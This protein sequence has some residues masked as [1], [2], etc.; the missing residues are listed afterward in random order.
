MYL[1]MLHGYKTLTVSFLRYFFFIASFLHI[2][3]P[4][5][6]FS[7]I[8]YG[9]KYFSVFCF[10]FLKKD[11][12]SFSKLK[13]LG[14]KNSS[15]F[16]LYF[17]NT[18][19]WKLLLLLHLCISEYP[20]LFSCYTKSSVLAWGWARNVQSHCGWLDQCD[21]FQWSLYLTSIVY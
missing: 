5:S 6:L 9:Y 20:F 18:K 12:P 3:I 2:V 1:Y 13:C 17:S 7:E 19:F 14:L 21:Q 15:E 16:Y 8:N 11:F 10:A 4:K